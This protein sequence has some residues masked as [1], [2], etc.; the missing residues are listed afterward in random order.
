M[1]P[2]VMLTPHMPTSMLM[3]RRVPRLVEKYSKLSMDD[4]SAWRL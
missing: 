1:T 2:S 3:S 4:R